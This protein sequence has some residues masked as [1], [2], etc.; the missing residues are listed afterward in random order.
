MVTIELLNILNKTIDLKALFNQRLI[1][2]LSLKHG[3]SRLRRIAVESSVV[4]IRRG[5]M[6]NIVR[7][8]Q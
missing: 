7:Q 1:S 8:I 4:N 6:S 2:C 5:R 3:H